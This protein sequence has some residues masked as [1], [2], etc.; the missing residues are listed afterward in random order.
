[1]IRI[2]NRDDPNPILFIFSM[3]H[4]FVLQKLN[5]VLTNFGSGVFYPRSTFEHVDYTGRPVI[6][7][8]G[9]GAPTHPDFRDVSGGR[10]PSGYR[11][12][13]QVCNTSLDGDLQRADALI[14]DADLD[15][16]ITTH[17][18]RFAVSTGFWGRIA[19][20]VM[21][22]VDSTN[23]VL[24]F[25]R[26]GISAG[27]PNDTFSQV[28]NTRD[29]EPR[30]IVHSIPVYPIPLSTGIMTNKTENPVWQVG[31]VPDAESPREEKE[32]EQVDS[33]QSEIEAL[34]EENMQLRALAEQLVAKL[35]EIQQAMEL[36]AREQAAAV[37]ATTP[38]PA[39]T[40]AAVGN[41]A[42]TISAQIG[43]LK[44]ENERM[45]KKCQDY[46][47]E[48]LEKTL[49]QNMRGAAGRREY[50]ADPTEFLRQAIRS[51]S[52]VQVTNTASE[53]ASITP[54]RTGVQ[55]FATPEYAYSRQIGNAG[56]GK[57]L[58]ALYGGMKLDSRD[59]DAKIA[60]RRL[61]DQYGGV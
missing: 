61:G 16:E 55:T 8:D 15:E 11:V 58:W 22:G 42:D 17:P 54:Q 19:N 23:H 18:D 20:N 3:L 24:L 36:A 2:R 13:G 49:P 7:W 57:H 1:M 14:S 25:R 4:G 47:W 39:P 59:I 45:K 56:L 21:R 48:Q 52:A 38:A 29:M 44:A 26:D 10:L 6:F 50:D 32:S 37:P 5:S 30:T 12:V 9:N 41:V 35:Q 53:G 51:V 40:A 43:N 46:E 60:L 27:E 33:Q 31:N 34:K 28:C